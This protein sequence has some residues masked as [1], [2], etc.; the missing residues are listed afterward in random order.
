MKNIATCTAGTSLQIQSHARHIHSTAP[1]TQQRL[2]R[3]TTSLRNSTCSSTS[4]T[5]EWSRVR[6]LRVC[7]CAA[8]SHRSPW[9]TGQ[10]ATAAC[11]SS[12]Q[13][14]HWRAAAFGCCCGRTSR[15]SRS[16]K[17]LGSALAPGRPCRPGCRRWRRPEGGGA[18]SRSRRCARRSARGGTAGG[19]HS[20][21]SRWGNRGPLRRTALA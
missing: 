18:G 6:L 17:F 14:A 20:A 16:A 8:P 12:P 7:Q 4:D 3:P 10:R 9:H 5:T 21:R 13:A 1:K 2:A 19:R 11:A 15:T